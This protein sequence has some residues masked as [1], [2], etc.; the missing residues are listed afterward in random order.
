MSIEGVASKWVGPQCIEL[1][2][3]VCV[4]VFR[5]HWIGVE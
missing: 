2:V 3:C 1:C 5:A 4:A